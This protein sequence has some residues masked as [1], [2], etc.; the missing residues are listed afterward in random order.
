MKRKAEYQ[1]SKES[2]NITDY[3]SSSKFRDIP[4]LPIQKFSTCWFFSILSFILSSPEIQY[5]AKQLILQEIQTDPKNFLS[6]PKTCPLSPSRFSLLKFIF[7]ILYNR[8]L[9][10]KTVE[11][12]EKVLTQNFSIRS[13]V[14]LTG[15]KERYLESRLNIILDKLGLSMDTLNETKFGYGGWR[16]FPT[17]YKRKAE[18]ILVEFCK[19]NERGECK[20]GAHGV[21]VYDKFQKRIQTKSGYKSRPVLR[22]VIDSNIGIPLLVKGSIEQTL[23]PYYKGY[24]IEGHEVLVTLMIKRNT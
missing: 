8:N 15:M 16:R 4:G 14:H 5:H 19:Y 18:Y 13:N 24:T 7:H 1:L 6:F 3:L 12:Y 10:L 20:Y 17:G 9:L 11:N 21:C 22:Y 2:L 23:A